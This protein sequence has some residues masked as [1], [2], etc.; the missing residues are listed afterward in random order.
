MAQNCTVKLAPSEMNCQSET[1]ASLK[2]RSFNTSPITI[3]LF[4][5]SRSTTTS[6]RRGGWLDR[7]VKVFIWSDYSWW[8]IGQSVFFAP[9][10]QMQ[11]VHAK[12]AKTGL[13]WLIDVT[14]GA[15]KLSCPLTIRSQLSTVAYRIPIAGGGTDGLSPWWEIW[16]A[17]FSGLW[18]WCYEALLQ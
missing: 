3:H 5:K 16:Q 14:N 1:S 13:L 15:K 6:Y 10:L 17:Q 11:S 9:D 7:F 18:W 4:L 2:Y 8:K 12:D